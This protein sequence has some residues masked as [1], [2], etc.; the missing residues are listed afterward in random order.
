MPDLSHYLIFHPDRYRQRIGVTADVLINDQLHTE[1]SGDIWVD[2]VNNGNED[3]YVFHDPW[4]FSY[5]HASQLRRNENR[6]DNYV[7]SGSYL[8][9]CSADSVNKGIIQIDTVFV[10][11]TLSRWNRTP[12]LALPDEFSYLA[13]ERTNPL[14][15]RHFRFP[16]LPGELAQ[17]NSVTHTYLSMSWEEGFLEYS[18][19]P[20]NKVCKRI[21]FNIS[22]LSNQTASIINNRINRKYP[23][24]LTQCQLNEIISFI[25]R[26][27]S[28]KVIRQIR[29]LG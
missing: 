25:N 5:C 23:V 4:L 13:T 29:P 9:F 27:T 10:V 17:H 26:V 19:L 18:F 3:P 14:W 11:G 12:A 24:L 2:E 22:S 6:T 21:E 20:L 16:L 15:R 1:W 8:I 28:I 7:N